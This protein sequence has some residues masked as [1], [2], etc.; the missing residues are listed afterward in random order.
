MANSSNPANDLSSC[1][2]EVPSRT[3]P[4]GPN[5]IRVICLLPNQFE[6]RSRLG[7]FLC[8]RAKLYDPSALQLRSPLQRFPEVIRYVELNYLCHD[9]L[10][11]LVCLCGRGCN[12]LS[13]SDSPT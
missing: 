9:N 5:P 8:L 7:C 6:T 2:D 11:D 1:E 3:I 4:C 12:Q 13:S 10:L